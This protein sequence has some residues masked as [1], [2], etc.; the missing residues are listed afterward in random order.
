MLIFYLK[1]RFPP[2]RSESVRSTLFSQDAVKQLQRLFSL[3]LMNTLR[4]YAVAVKTLF[5]IARGFLK[6]DTM[7]LSSHQCFGWLVISCAGNS[8]NMLHLGRISTWIFS[9]S[10]SHFLTEKTSIEF[11]ASSLFFLC[12]FAAEVIL[13]RL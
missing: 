4:S 6:D 7:P 13:C 5:P 1:C 3:T 8:K 9:L 11:S 12:N 10:S 2:S